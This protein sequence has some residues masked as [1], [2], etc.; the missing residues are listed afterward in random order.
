MSCNPL[1]ICHEPRELP[2]I[3]RSPSCAYPS[4]KYVIQ[5]GTYNSV[6]HL[7]VPGR[8]NRPALYYEYSL[9]SAKMLP[10]SA[11]PRCPIEPDGIRMVVY[12]R[13]ETFYIYEHTSESR[14]SQAETNAGTHRVH[15]RAAQRN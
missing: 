13:G 3:L 11:R 15:L 8:R 1:F 9:K 12:F 6:A 14:T 7:S 4:Q 10:S 2:T 5:C